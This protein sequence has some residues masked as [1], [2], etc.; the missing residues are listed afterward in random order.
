M[1]GV[2]LLLK[3]KINR[4]R[5]GIRMNSNENMPIELLGLSVRSYNCLKQDKINTVGEL[6]KLSPDEIIEIKHLGKKS[7]EELFEVIEKIASGEFQQALELPKETYASIIENPIHF[8]KDGNIIKAG[9]KKVLHYIDNMT[10][11]KEVQDVLFYNINEI[12]VDDV[13][14]QEM[15]LS[16]R[17]KGALL[18]G[19]YFTAQ[20]IVNLD[21]AD[22][23]EIKN[24]GSS[25]RDEILQVLKEKI[26]IQYTVGIN[27]ALIEKYADTI[28]E[29]IRLNCP[30]MKASIYASQI[31][32][33]VYKHEQFLDKNIENIL[34]HK[35]FMN[36]IYSESAIYR[37]FEN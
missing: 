26:Y 29:D 35:E 14:V 19:G 15:P 2:I 8:R 5:V 18:R 9:M 7:A 12:L 34:E 1:L 3:A 24:L 20:A 28:N 33:A 11:V 25:T 27:S 30:K 17:A 23:I 4:L 6:M 16:T 36:K 32:V 37:I 31:K 13:A 22:F 21:Y 10:V